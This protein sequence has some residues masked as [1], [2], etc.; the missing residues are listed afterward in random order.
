MHQVLLLIHKVQSFDIQGCKWTCAYFCHP[1]AENQPM[2]WTG[3]TKGMTS[4]K[5]D[6]SGVLN[7]PLVCSGRAIYK[8]FGHACR[9]YLTPVTVM[10]KNSLGIIRQNFPCEI[11]HTRRTRGLPPRPKKRSMPLLISSH[12]CRHSP[13]KISRA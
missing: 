8:V 2:H 13:H 5:S 10:H 9:I 12:G 3:Q 1:L 4:S 11:N 7:C 6:S